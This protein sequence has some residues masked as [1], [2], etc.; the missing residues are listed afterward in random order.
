LNA[1]WGAGELWRKGE[2]EREGG[3]RTLPF[4]LS[5]RLLFFAVGARAFT[6]VE[7]ILAISI[8]IGILVVALFFHSQASHLRAQLLDESDRIAAIRLVMERLTAELRSAFEQPQYGFTG[9]A[10]RP[11]CPA[12]SPPQ[13]RAP[14]C[15]SFPTTWAKCSKAPTRS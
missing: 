9:D 8:A 10:T 15:V 6:L 5:P 3:E 12:V 13:R 11:R 1:G 2:R 4:S 14:T 7:V